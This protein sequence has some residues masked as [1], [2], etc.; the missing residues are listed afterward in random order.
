M[1]RAV[2][3][4]FRDV[5][6]ALDQFYCSPASRVWRSR[7]DQHPG[8]DP[9]SA[10]PNPTFHFSPLQSPRP[11]QLSGKRISSSFLKLSPSLVALNR[12]SPAIE[13]IMAKTTTLKE[14]ESVFPKLVEDLLDHAKSY[15]LPEEF[16]DWYKAVGMDPDLRRRAS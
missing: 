3:A 4:R 8:Q 11:R 5:T 15:K 14:F 10:N 16:V 6:Q 9:V 12:C 2:T 7:L 1:R 13:V